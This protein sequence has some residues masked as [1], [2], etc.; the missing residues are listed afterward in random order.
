MHRETIA[1]PSVAKRYAVQAGA[2][3]VNEAIVF[4]CPKR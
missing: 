3:A 4:H 1:D 2:G